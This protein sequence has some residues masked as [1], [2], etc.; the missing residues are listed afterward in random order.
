[1]ILYLL[2]FFCLEQS[3][4]SVHIIHCTLDDYIPFC[5]YFVVPYVLWFAFMG[6]SLWYFAF[7][8]RNRMEYWQFVGTL[9][10]GLTVFLIVSFI[11][12]NG[13]ELRP[14]LGDGNIFVQ[15]VKFLYAIDTPTNLLPSMH[16]FVAVAC[17]VAICQNEDCLRH[18]LLIVGTKI[19]TVLIVLSTMFIKQHSVID[20]T[21]GLAFYALCYEVFYKV[22]PQY[23]NQLKELWTVK[24]I[25]TVPNLLSAFRL[26]LAILFWGICQRYGG[27]VKNREILTCI[28]ILS[29]ITDFL[30]G[31]IARRFHMVSEFGKFLDPI[32]DKATQGVLLLCLFS[33]Y[34]LTKPLFFLFAVKESYEAVIGT[35]TVIKMGANEG[36]QWYGKVSTMVFYVVMS[37]LV[38]FPNIPAN[39]AN[40]LILCCGSCMLL[41]LLMYARYYHILQQ[42]TSWRLEGKG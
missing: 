9:G 7:R 5:E 20:V 6:V 33:E 21:L 1:M 29:G 19:L 24:Q 41:A 26:V 27:I 15:A 34:S 22:L 39:V 12:P 4:A 17:C 31:K 32:A 36:A 3:N 38:L 28:L 10:V 25:L 16:V 23:R 2:S 8:C 30:D 42:N 14:V 37:V 35:K 18:K 13:H 11:Y 40:L